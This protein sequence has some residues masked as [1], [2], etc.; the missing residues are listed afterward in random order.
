MMVA[1]RISTAGFG[2]R[3]YV[4]GYCGPMPLSRVV[5]CAAAAG[6]GAAGGT[7]VGPPAVVVRAPP[8]AQPATTRI[9]PK[10]AATDRCRMRDLLFHEFK[11]QRRTGWRDTHDAARRLLGHV[12]DNG[13]LHAGQLQSIR[14]ERS[15][16]HG[17]VLDRAD[18]HAD[19][20]RHAVAR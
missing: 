20:F 5:S 13:E 18:L 10:A 16:R 6:E 12:H 1:L 3:R 9:P 11:D 19:R 4:E 17:D 7:G 8:D 2:C 15:S 14:R